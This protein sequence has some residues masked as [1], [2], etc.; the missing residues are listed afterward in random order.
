MRKL[1]QAVALVAAVFCA[2]P[3]FAHATSVAGPPGKI[4]F[5]SGR[6]AAD[7]PEPNTGDKRARIYVADYPS[8]T[9]IKVTTQ[10]SGDVRHRQPNWSPDH[11]RIAYAAGSGASY[12]IW[13]LDL[14]TGSQTEFVAPAPET[15]RPSWSPDGTEIAY[16]SEGD[17]WVKPVAGG[18]AV[19]ATDGAGVE[20]RPVW[21][22]DG[23]TLYYDKGTAPNR[24]L[25]KISPVAASSEE[26]LIPL[27]S[28]GDDWQVDVST[29]GQRLCFTRGAGGENLQLVGVNGGLVTAFAAGINCVWSPDGSEILYTFGTFGTGNLAKRDLSGNQG[30]VPASW[31]VDD[32]FDGNADWATN[33]S[34]ECDQRNVDVGVNQFT[35]V[36]LA[37]V[38]PDFGFGAAAPERD[39]ISENGMEIVNPPAHGTI[40]SITDD[41]QV[42]YT[43]NKD[44]K[45]TDTFTYAAEDNESTGDPATV[46]INVGTA[47]SGGDKVPPKI[48]GITVD[49]PTFRRGN[50]LA[51]ISAVPVGTTI[52]FKLSEAAKAKISFQR[53]T[54]VKGKTKFK[55]AGSTKALAAKAGKNKVKFQGRL[56][57]S[58]K[59]APG[60]YRIVV[61]ATD[62]AGNTGKKNGPTVKIVK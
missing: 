44:F 30:T 5:T 36:Q 43:P 18:A 32:H 50:K 13:I 46:T 53:K 61:T 26:N 6:I 31:A 3:V 55:N 21:S 58:K 60:S 38:D 49:H 35:T 54:K 9:P 7:V 10:P 33:F 16:G 27:S 56:T 42:I 25:Y 57:S 11:T 47:S 59:L 12:G 41:E 37:C 1:V 23:N 39:P 40:G 24:D 29:D 2:F 19:K 62:G 8:G 28:G 20:E 52:R 17:I 51:S 14:R 48:S 34:P 22:P 15:D 4:A 45:G